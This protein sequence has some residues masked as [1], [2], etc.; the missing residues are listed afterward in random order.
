MHYAIEN[1]RASL[2]LRPLMLSLVQSERVQL[3]LVN[4]CQYSH[5]FA[6]ATNVWTTV[7]W[8]P[9][10]ASGTGLCRAETGYCSSKTH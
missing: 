9:K 3:E 1:P 10:G 5:I 7:G 4:Y 6:K 8:T 2:R